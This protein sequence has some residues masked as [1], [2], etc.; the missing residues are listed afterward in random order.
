MIKAY[1]LLLCA[2]EC[3][4]IVLDFI[5]Q[6]MKDC[7]ELFPVT[8]YASVSVPT[9]LGGQ[10]GLIVTSKNEVCYVGHQLSVCICMYVYDHVPILRE[11]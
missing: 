2:G 7:R 10:V 11:P 5:Q 8:K 9:F 3:M 6:V 4:W 1:Y